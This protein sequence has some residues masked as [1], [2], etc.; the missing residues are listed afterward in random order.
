MSEF[1]RLLDHAPLDGSDGDKESHFGMVRETILRIKEQEIDGLIKQLSPAQCDILMK[2]LYRGLAA[3]DQKVCSVFLTWH[4][5]LTTAAGIGS[6][7]RA[8]T[9]KRTV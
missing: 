8:L 2:Y 7:M 1:K 5:R 9:D 3:A 4:E 6:I